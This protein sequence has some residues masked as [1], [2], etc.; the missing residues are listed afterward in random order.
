MT[1]CVDRGYALQVKTL[2][3]EVDLRIEETKKGTHEFK[4]DIIVA[5]ENPKTGKTASEKFIK[6]APTCP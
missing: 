4:R 3:E 1:A 6:Y 2:L 5:A